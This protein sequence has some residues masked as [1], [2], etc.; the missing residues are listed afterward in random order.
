MTMQDRA[1]ELKC[2]QVQ[3]Q[4]W[5]GAPLLRPIL[6]L[7]LSSLGARGWGCDCAGAL[8]RGRL[9]TVLLV[10]GL[11]APLISALPSGIAPSSNMSS[12]P[13]SKFTHYIGMQSVG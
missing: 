1:V 10:A 9:A 6:L 2:L 8:L 4:A 11:F 7:G 13:C 5:Q 3:P 12:A